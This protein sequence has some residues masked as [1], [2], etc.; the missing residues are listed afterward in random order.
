MYLFT[1]FVLMCTKHNCYVSSCQQHLNTYATFLL[2]NVGVIYARWGYLQ[3][4]TGH[5]GLFMLYKFDSL[6]LATRMLHK[7]SGA[8]HDGIDDGT[9]IIIPHGEF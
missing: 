2:P 7:Y 6:A 1:N 4:R 5:S 8:V 9:R 3:P